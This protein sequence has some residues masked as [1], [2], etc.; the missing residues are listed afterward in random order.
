MVEWSSHAPAAEADSNI[1]VE[2]ISHLYRKTQFPYR[3]HNS[4]LSSAS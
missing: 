3:I 4:L 1:T 2:E